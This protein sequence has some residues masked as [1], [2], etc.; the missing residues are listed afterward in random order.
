MCLVSHGISS[1]NAVSGPELSEL[2][3]RMDTAKLPSLGRAISLSCQWCV[4]G[5]TS[6]SLA[7]LGLWP[8]GG[9]R[10]GLAFLTVVV[11]VV[12]KKECVLVVRAAP[13]QIPAPASA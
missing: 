10:I 7:A 12:W 2:A 1:S 13:G 11:S 9:V 6:P 4:R 3:I 5:P 8:V